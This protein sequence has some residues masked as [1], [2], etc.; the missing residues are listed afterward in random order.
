MLQ[1][2]TA[3][4]PVREALP[5]DLHDFVVELAVAVH[6]RAIY[7]PTHPM[8]HGAVDAVYVRLSA[9]LQERGSLSLGTANKRL[10]VEGINT[11]DEHPLLKELAAQLHSHQLGAI[12]F[13]S[14]LT[15][16]EL[17]EAID[18]I[19]VSTIRGAE[20]LGVRPREEINRW[21][22]VQL[23][24]MAF[25]RLQLIDGGDAQQQ[26]ANGQ[27]GVL[28]LALARAA[29]AS[30]WSAS[31][32]DDPR[33]VA[34]CI[35]GH[36]GDDGYD[37]VVIGCLVQL[38]GEMR[39]SGEGSNKVVRQRVS[40]L[41]SNLSERGIARLLALGG[42]E[43]KSQRERLLSD[44]TESLAARAV[45]DLVRV[46]SSNSTA[47]ISNAM[48][49][50]LGK[51][52]REAEVNDAR[53]PEAD[54]MLRLTVKRL[55]DGWTLDN[56][57]P[58]QYD[59]VLEAAPRQSSA[60]PDQK[61]DLAEPERMLDLALEVEVVGLGTEAILA[62]LVA[63]DGIGPTLELVQSYAPNAIRN[64]MLERLLNESA[65]R[66]HLATDRPEMQI[67][68]QAADRL[69][70]KMVPQLVSAMDRRPDHD[71]SWISDLLV[72]IGFDSL[73][74]LGAELATASPRVTRYIL[75]VFE[76]I[77]AWPPRVDPISFV[78]HFDSSVR[79]EA[80]KFLLKSEQTREQAVLIAVRDPDLRILNLGL[81]A[82][83]RSC[84]ADC[85]RILMRRLEEDHSLTSELRVRL[86]RAT[87]VART[88]EV[89][90]WLLSLATRTRWL[91]RS[92][93]LRN[94]A[95][96]VIAA[97]TSIAAHFGDT[98]EGAEVV[99]LGRES[100]TDEFRRAATAARHSLAEAG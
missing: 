56:P 15:R 70:G 99:A 9:L 32:A 44:A 30:Q 90:E 11:D 81:N 86:I 62:R 69:K 92:R 88:P 20:P 5:R 35:D 97:V 85:A 13:N 72:R 94:A 52:A 29:L 82:T 27:G 45:V 34:A 60:G 36:D 22:G 4:A 33:Q 39:A 48:L 87:S 83:A 65:I 55:L 38:M 1:T 61:R 66:E 57:N 17:S 80:L 67:L 91:T 89:L 25:D 41:L 100:R 77:D 71:A 74:P 59:K 16:D 95:P 96:E 21:T 68:E 31:A 93:K 24:P 46:A 8:L 42:A 50:L 58:K 64:E 51:L 78:R 40:E 26:D 47:P 28:W 2:P 54:R 76:R 18:D 10:I 75:G 7:P 6:K 84:S 43:A 19:S 98:A 73:E 37:Q 79:R 49:R 53:S 3:P 12:R 14:D 63:R 23:F